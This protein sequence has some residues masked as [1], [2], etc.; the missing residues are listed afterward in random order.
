MLSVSKPFKGAGR[1]DYY[2]NLAREDY[3]LDESEP[4]GRWLGEGSILFRLP[5]FVSG[6][7]FRNLLAGYDAD[8]AN[9]L[10]HNAGSPKRRSGWDLTWSV[11]KSV[12]VAW[13]QATPEVRAEI[14]GAVREAVRRAISYLEG[15][16]VVS[17]RGTDG[18][19]HEKAKLIFAAF[20]HS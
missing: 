4:P 9:A 10:V 14:E 19:M 1:A 3:Y 11:P 6:D 12:S 18:V 5:E 16:G 13:S 17:R 2:L 8:R 15:V 7:D 20:E